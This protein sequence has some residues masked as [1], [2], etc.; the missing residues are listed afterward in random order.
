MMVLKRYKPTTPSMRS[1]ILVDKSSLWKGKPVK[2][3]SKGVMRINGRNNQGRQT[4]FHRGGGHKK[5]Y[6][7]I[8]FIL[9][10][11][12]QGE[13]IRLEYDPKRT[14]FIALVK[15]D[16][17]KLFYTLA[18]NGLNVG[19]K[20]SYGSDIDIRTGNTLPLLNIPVGTVIN[21]IEIIPG[22]GGQLVRSAGCSSQLIQKRED[23]YVLIRLPS[24]E[25]RMVL[26]KCNATIGTISNIDNKNKIMGK[27]GR[28]RWM[29][30]RPI[31][32]GVAMNP[33]DHPHGGGEGK[34]SGGRPSVTP[35]GLPTKGKPTRSVRKKNSLILERVKNK[36]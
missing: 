18:L 15:D 35:W 10:N 33:V 23:G 17:G 8:S 1:T 31:V 21:N 24:G 22:K 4:L 2:S 9:N 11:L 28:S 13:I 32:R 3:L 27:A 7:N 6:R 14:S 5:K 25:I 16:C 29:G 20:I 36:K 19:D 34:T 30:R 12:V 26:G